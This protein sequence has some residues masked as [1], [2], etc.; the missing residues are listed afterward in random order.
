MSEPLLHGA[1]IRDDARVTA[2][3]RA[4]LMT[5]PHDHHTVHPRVGRP[6][7]CRL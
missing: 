3:L 4:I 6:L 1:L 5:K 7:L 2:R